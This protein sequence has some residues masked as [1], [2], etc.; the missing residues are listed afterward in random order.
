MNDYILPVIPEVKSWTREEGDTV[1][2]RAVYTDR[3]EWQTCVNTFCQAFEKINGCTVVN[4]PG[5]VELLYDASIRP[6]G[7][8]ITTDGGIR[9]YASAKEGANYAL[10]TALQL[11]TPRGDTVYM[12]KVTIEDYPDKDYRAL[13][14]DLAR[15]WHPA[16][17]VYKYIDLCY[18]LKIKYIQLHFGDDQ[19]YTLP[20]RVFPNLS[21]PGADPIPSP[22]CSP[23]LTTRRHGA[24]SP[25]PKSTCPDTL[26]R[27]FRPIRRSSVT[28]STRIN[29]AATLSVRAVPKR[30]RPLSG[31]STRC[32]GCS[33]TL[34]ISISAVMRP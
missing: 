27:S 31:L 33:R 11:L 6:D 26:R 24:L 18:L 9:L 2:A 30:K 32:A 1:C 34:L 16:R 25:F 14:V 29:G 21:T 17:T 8:R 4:Q 22:K 15:G 28:R 23:L 13:M 7:Y 5:G 19:S 10:V 3:P 20:S 12:P